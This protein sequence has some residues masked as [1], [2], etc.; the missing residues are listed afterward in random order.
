MLTLFTIPIS[1]PH[2]SSLSMSSRQSTPIPDYERPYQVNE[3]LTLNLE[4][5]SDDRSSN[6]IRVQIV[7]VQARWT[8]SCGMVVKIMDPESIEGYP[9]LASTDT[10]FLK[11]YDWRHAHS[12]RKTNQLKL[13]WDNEIEEL[14]TDFIKSG[15]A[16]KFL[17]ELEADKFS[18][19]MNEKEREL[20]MA[21]DMLELYTFE[22]KA[23]NQLKEHHGQA[24]PRLLASVTRDLSPPGIV[25]S[26][27][28]V[29]FFHIK[30]LLLQFLDGFNLDV[31]E[32]NAPREAWQDIFDQA[33][34]VLHVVDSKDILNLDVRPE[35]FI[36][37][38][39]SDQK[40]KVF[41]IDLGMTLLRADY[42]CDMDW[43]NTKWYEDE[44]G[45]LGK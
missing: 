43:K 3:V 18:G 16:D 33:L 39:E 29:R 13:P 31:L 2:Y 37:I 17:E 20:Y 44:G 40:H 36:V 42:E 15:E 11:L 35:N 30:G 27:A 23:Y 19:K 32:T 24:V 45:H 12:H 26:P 4:P 28:S 21:G 41:L 5:T 1:P 10:A 7:K 25:H 8:Y 34:N 9:E 6:V 38:P 22:I 14:Y